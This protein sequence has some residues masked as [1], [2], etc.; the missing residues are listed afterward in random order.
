MS[1]DMLF[2]ISKVLDVDVNWLISGHTSEEHKKSLVEY[3]KNRRKEGNYQQQINDGLPLLD[4]AGQAKVAEYVDD[5]LKSGK[6]TPKRP[7]ALG[8]DWVPKEGEPD[9]VDPQENDKDGA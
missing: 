2:P 3:V 1:L 4:T 8:G 5:L 6:H 7:I 9:A